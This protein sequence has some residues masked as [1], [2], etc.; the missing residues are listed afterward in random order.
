VAF[1]ETSRLSIKRQ[2]LSHTENV[3]TPSRSAKRKRLSISHSNW[4]EIFVSDQFEPRFSLPLFPG[5]CIKFSER[6]CVRPSN[7]DRRRGARDTYIDSRLALANYCAILR[8]RGRIRERESCS[9]REL[10][11]DLHGRFIDKIRSVI[12]RR[13]H[14]G[15][16]DAVGDNVGLRSKTLPEYARVTFRPCFTSNER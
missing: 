8:N 13:Y 9:I 10:S 11:S 2:H 14:V 15:S 4:P 3:D 16:R 7:K 5:G 6:E 12:G 1:V